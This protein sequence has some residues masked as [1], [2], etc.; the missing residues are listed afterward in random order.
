MLVY[1]NHVLPDPLHSMLK[2][3]GALSW[4]PDFTVNTPFFRMEFRADE[5]EIEQGLR[6]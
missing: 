2:T 4:L 1:C 3:D 6:R 5:D